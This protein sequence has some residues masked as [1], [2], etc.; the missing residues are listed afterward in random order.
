MRLDKLLGDVQVLSLRGDPAGTDIV[1]VTS[2][3]EAVVPGALFFCVRGSR[4]DGHRFA[5]RAVAAGAAALV[6]E[7]DVELPPGLG[8]DVPQVLV[9][10]SRAALAPAAAAF[11]VHP[12]RRLS[13]VGVTG[14][15]GKTT[16]THLLGAVLRADGRPAEVIGTLS[17]ART[18]PEAPHL[19]AALAAAAERGT[20]AVALEVSSH[21]LTLHRV[22]ATWFEVAVFTNLTPEHLDFHDTMDDYFAAKASLFTPDRT[23]VAVVNADDPWGRRLLESTAVPTR[24]FTLADAAG[25][26]IGPDGARFAWE[27]RPVWLRPGAEFNVANALAAATAARELGVP[28]A[29]VADG[30]SAAGP[31]P[32]RFEAIDRG[33]GF[34]V[35]VDYAHTPA[36]L[37]A[38]LVA[39]RQLAG[40]G[41]ASAPPG[42]VIVVFGCGGDRD[43]AKRPLMGDVATRLA[44]VA[45]LTSDNPRSEDPA[46]IIDAVVAGARRPEALVVEPDRRSAIALAL[47]DARP[48]DVVVV[49]GKGHEATQV[50]GDRALPFDD[51]VVAGELLEGLTSDISRTASGGQW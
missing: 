3:S 23:A 18:T 11:Y 14:T 20:Q 50:V 29:T 16:T 25:L 37:E 10:D 35:I 38:C 8:A 30:L 49:A 48:G 39:A 7:E 13:V 1:A 41:G 46:A 17:G 40:N 51:R 43:K 24:P 28:A 15:N 19:Q 34:A 45:V 32:G 5:A 4:F 31:V 21:A 42:R 12:S 36:G 2:D 27:G 33:Q 6:V 22:D 44:D 26:A 9:A 47:D